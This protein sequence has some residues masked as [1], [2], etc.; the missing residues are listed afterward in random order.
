MLKFHKENINCSLY[1]PDNQKQNK[2]QEVFHRMLKI[3]CETH[4]VKKMLT[5][6][7]SRILPEKQY[8]VFMLHAI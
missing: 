6:F 1:P 2:E 8:Y 3:L 7:I 5:P 4:H